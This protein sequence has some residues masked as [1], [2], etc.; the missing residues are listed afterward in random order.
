MTEPYWMRMR[1]KAIPQSLRTLLAEVETATIGHFEYVGF[2]GALITPVF[3]AKAIGTAI[4]V[5][6]PGRDGTVIYKAIDLLTPG[7]ALVI[8]RVDQDDVACVGGGVVAAARAR[9]AV[10]VIVDGPCTDVEEIR[11]S[12][13]PVWC[14]G[15]SSKTTSRRH[16]IGG[17]IN[18]AIACGGAAVLPGYAVLADNEGV[19]VAEPSHM[20]RVAD[21]ALRRQRHSLQLRPHLEAG[22]SIFDLDQIVS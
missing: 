11:A 5:A 20:R 9:G 1:P 3:P 15:V 2:V 4:T 12:Q 19:F 14:R 13:F 6:A 21:F 16:K 8:S 22:H 7:D 18:V 10:A 17:A